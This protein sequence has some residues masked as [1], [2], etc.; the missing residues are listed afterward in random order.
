MDSLDQDEKELIDGAR[1]EIQQAGHPA[2]SV[3]GPPAIDEQAVKAVGGEVVGEGQFA[4]PNA[5]VD[6]VN[7]QTKALRAEVLGGSATVGE[8]DSDLALATKRQMVEEKVEAN[9]NSKVEFNS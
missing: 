6:F 7:R 3:S 4:E 9:A 8:G 5:I 2:Q 1:Q